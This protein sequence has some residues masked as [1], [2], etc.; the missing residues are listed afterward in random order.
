MLKQALAYAP[1]SA[2][3]RAALSLGLLLGFYVTILGLALVLFA[4]PVL[5]MMA[6]SRVSIHLLLL[7]AVC[8]VPAAVGV[9]RLRDATTGVR[10]ARS[11]PRPTWTRAITWP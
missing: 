6:L 10:P 7:A 8:W 3:A 4:L 9:Q 2:L 1:P 5:G 11:P